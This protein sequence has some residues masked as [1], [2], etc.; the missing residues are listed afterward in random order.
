MRY[1]QVVLWMILLIQIA[2]QWQRAF[3]SCVYNFTWDGAQ[4][5]PYYNIQADIPN[6]SET[7]YALLAGPAFMFLFGTLSLFSGM[8]SDIF[9]N[10][11]ILC[12]SCIIWSLCSMG[13]GWCQNFPLLFGLRIILD[14]CQANV[15]P[16]AYGL[17]SNYFPPET[18]TS[19]NALYA[20]GIYLGAGLTNF[21]ILLIDNYG[22]RESY[23]IVGAIGL[24]SGI[25]SFIIIKEPPRNRFAV[26]KKKEEE[27]PAEPVR[28][29][30]VAEEAAVAQVASDL[31]LNA[32]KT[33]TGNTT[34][35][36]K[37]GDD[38]KNLSYLSST[39]E[40]QSSFQIDNKLKNVA[41]SEQ[42]L[43]SDSLITVPLSN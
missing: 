38:N 2:N 40:G 21:S 5:N 10:R 7:M 35:S 36:S 9:N 20:L 42:S 4:T 29:L 24:V 16:N 28:S 31:N 3:V 27:K 39:H 41:D 11:N 22:W 34:N 17:I 12:S 8:I 25:L 19:A 13:S 32:T 1:S 6:F 33:T 15:A 26:V 14:V 18:R 30:S 43:L 37:I 23:V